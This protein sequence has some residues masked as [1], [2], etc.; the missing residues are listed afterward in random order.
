MKL[1]ILNRQAILDDIFR[2][3]PQM[4]SEDDCAENIVVPFLLRLGFQKANIRR[5]VTVTGPSGSRLRKQADIVIG[6]DQN[7]LAVIEVKKLRHRLA[8]EDA[9]Q[10]LSY[11]RLVRPPAPLAILT[12]GRSWEVYTLFDDAVQSLEG[13]PTKCDAEPILQ[14]SLG[15]TLAPQELVAAERLLTT[16]E[17][18][19][20]LEEAFRECRTL[21]ARGEGF[22][23]ETAFD[24]LTKI[25]ACK[26]DEEKRAMEGKGFNRF[27]KSYVESQGALNALAQMFTDAK[28]TFHVFPLNDQIK[29]TKNEVALGIVEALEPFGIYGF[30]SPLGLATTGG[31]IVGTVYE[32]FLSGTLR[33]ELGQYLTPRQIVQF[34]AQI[35]EVKLGER[36]L[37]LTCGSAGF[38]IEVFLDVKKQIRM[39]DLTESEKQE[40][41]RSLV[42]ND[43]W[44]I[45][46]NPRLATLSRMNLILH[47]DGYEHIYTGDSIV[48][49]VFTN[50]DGRSFDFHAIEIGEREGFDAILM[51]PPFNL[52]VTGPIL[53]RYTLG[54]GKES[55]GSDFLLIERAIRLLRVETG[56]L[57]IVMPHTVASGPT[58]KYLRD[59]LKQVCNVLGVISLP[60]GAFKPFGG[61]NARTCILYI[62]KNPK[63]RDKPLFKAEARNIGYDVRTKYYKEIDENDLLEIADA[64]LDY[65]RRNKL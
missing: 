65:R 36:T 39:S 53:N 11:A 50:M 13:V 17:Q 30:R 5:K 22:I 61:S 41:L 51:N 31:D 57:V 33:G 25:L 6:I 56:R 18:R 8:E 45:D 20:A 64:F 48:D 60:V 3:A 47:G 55:E 12:N 54:R 40:R 46:L 29:I 21:L 34:C 14:K 4:Y 62:T 52:P 28:S 1:A 59:Y 7:S 49:D 44:G 27:R 10:A 32:T 35:A 16:L 19:E 43:L 9:N 26:F 2:T 15:I 23:S 37:D 24:E 58:E 38:L 42:D 63:H